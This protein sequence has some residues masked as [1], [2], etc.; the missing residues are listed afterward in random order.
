VKAAARSVLL[1]IVLALAL[2]ACDG[3]A[4][5][6]P[7]PTAAPD[8]GIRGLVLLGPTCAVEQAGASPCVT[9][10]AATLV[11]RD[12]NERE[13][14]RVTSGAD[15]RF[16]IRL[17]PGQY[18]ILPQNGDPTPTAQLAPVTVVEGQFADVTINYD[19]GIR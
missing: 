18:V 7:S 19:T 16:E 2:S 9:P 13:V 6:T 14:G 12:A 3:T 1:L 8:T 17:P 15:G 4:A 5:T 10:Y 11:I